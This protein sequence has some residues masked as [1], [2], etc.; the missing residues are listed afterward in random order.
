MVTCI[1]VSVTGIVH[2]MFIGTMSGYIHEDVTEQLK[3]TIKAS[4]SG[5]EDLDQ[6]AMDR[7]IT[8]TF[9]KEETKT[10]L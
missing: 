8:V 9:A 3:G 2:Y 7:T 4:E 5:C 6:L 10:A 1:D